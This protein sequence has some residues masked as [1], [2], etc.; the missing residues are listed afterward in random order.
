MV[1]CLSGHD[2]SGGAGIQA[3]I[4]SIGAQ[5]CHPAAIITCLT[6][7]NT[8]NARKIHPISADLLRNQLDL[9]QMDYEIA[10]IKIGLLGSTETAEAVSRIVSDHPHLPIVL[11]P[12]LAAGGGTDFTSPQLLALIREKL[13]PNVLQDRS[14]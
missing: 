11:D 4:E 9:L 12:V 7:Q 1:L 2:P 10:A 8:S 3:D 5:G 6:E 14:D 13:L